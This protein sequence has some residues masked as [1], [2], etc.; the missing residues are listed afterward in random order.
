MK[1]YEKNKPYHKG[2]GPLERAE[3]FT[4]RPP[5]IGGQLLFQKP[6]NAVNVRTSHA[7]LARI[8]RV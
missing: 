6:Q 5:L 3:Y 2:Q 7:F 1:C 8:I 4:Q